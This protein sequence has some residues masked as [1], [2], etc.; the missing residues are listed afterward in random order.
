MYRIVGNN[1]QIVRGDTAVINIA[2]ST[3]DGAK[4]I[5]SGG[6]N[7][8]FTVRKTATDNI[9][10]QKTITGGNFTINPVDTETLEFGN[11]VYDVQLTSAS[12]FTDTIIAPHIFKI[13]EEVT[14]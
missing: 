10:I 13:L 5:L 9:V 2:V 6:D 11:Y 14:Y 4:Y 8:T 7:L 12:G 1:I 3:K